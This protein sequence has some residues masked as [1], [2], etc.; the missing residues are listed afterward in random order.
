LEC[1]YPPHTSCTCPY[2]DPAPRWSC[3]DTT[4][5]P[6]GTPTSGPAAIPETKRIKDLSNAEAQ[7]WCEWFLT[8]YAVGT[9]PPFEGPITAEGYATGL[10]FTLNPNFYANVCMPTE[11]PTTYCV[12]N[13]KL[14]PCE[15]TVGELSDCVLTVAR[16][17]PAVH[18]CGRFLE[19]A[20][21]SQTIFARHDD[22]DAGGGGCGSLK[23]R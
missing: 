18:G 5:G 20:S 7:I 2:N 6:P 22:S 4:A 14:F 17:V 21:C 11:V 1:P 9:P 23:V 19:A 13:L 3:V 15:A 8:K 10:G 12:A 16:G